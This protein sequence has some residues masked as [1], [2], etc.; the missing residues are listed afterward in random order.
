MFMILKFRMQVHQKLPVTKHYNTFQN[1]TNI[2][3]GTSFR[4]NDKTRQAISSFV[5]CSEMGI[6]YNCVNHDLTFIFR[7]DCTLISVT[8]K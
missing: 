5:Q 2:L 3:S 8:Q 4:S 6:K 1:I 7:R